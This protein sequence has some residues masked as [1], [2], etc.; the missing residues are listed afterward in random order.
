MI[1]PGRDRRDPRQPSFPFRRPDRKTDRRTY[2]EYSGSGE[3]VD[4]VIVLKRTS[5]WV[6][7][8]GVLLR[9]GS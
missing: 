9:S 8:A 3:G 7:V 5:V 2:C 1:Y 4:P 6:G